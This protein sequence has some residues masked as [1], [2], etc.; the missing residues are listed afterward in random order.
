MS[1]TSLC[2]TDLSAQNDVIR[3]CGWTVGSN[4]LGTTCWYI[5]QTDEGSHCLITAGIETPGL[6]LL[7]PLLHAMIVLAKET[8]LFSI[9]LPTL[10]QLS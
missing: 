7:S 6:A 2:R 8:C 5:P 3:H 9:T 1:R 10:T 4:H